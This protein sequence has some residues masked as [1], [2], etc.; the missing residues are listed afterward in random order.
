MLGRPKAPG[1]CKSRA[2][3][4]ADRGPRG[5]FAGRAE[6]RSAGGVRAR[7]AG[8]PM[9]LKRV[10]RSEGSEEGVVREGQG[11]AGQG[12]EGKGRGGRKE[13]LASIGGV[14]KKQGGSWYFTILDQQTCLES[15]GFRESRLSS[16]LGSWSAIPKAV[17]G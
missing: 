3:T 10:G 8:R 12:R 15:L 6:R 9:E 1:S 13:D 11:R 5:F 2:M 16:S 14:A 17:E 7:V 4:S